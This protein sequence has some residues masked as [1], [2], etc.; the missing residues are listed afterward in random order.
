MPGSPA[1]P[2]PP[3][4]RSSPAP[5]WGSRTSATRT[6]ARAIWRPSARTPSARPAGRGSGRS[7]PAPFPARCA[8]APHRR[9]ARVARLRLQEPA[10]PRRVPGGVDELQLVL[11]LRYGVR[12]LRAL[13]GRPGA[14]R[15]HSHRAAGV[16]P[17]VRVRVHRLAQE[18]PGPVLLDRGPLLPALRAAKPARG[19]AGVQAATTARRVLRPFLHRE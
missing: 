5:A 7:S 2:P 4:I 15:R 9:D 18:A 6:W 8:T 10:Q 19:Y 17:V 1:S 11:V 12:F 3:S 13:R 14:G 16:V